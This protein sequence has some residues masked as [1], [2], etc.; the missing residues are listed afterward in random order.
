MSFTSFVVSISISE[1]AISVY[2]IE[3]QGDSDPDPVPTS[4]MEARNM[5]GNPYDTQKGKILVLCHAILPPSE[6]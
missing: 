4:K 6:R 3:I 1:L 2:E 5:T